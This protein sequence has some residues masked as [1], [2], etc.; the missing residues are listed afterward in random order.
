MNSDTLHWMRLALAALNGL[1]FA[2]GVLWL[3]RTAWF[4][5]RRWRQ[6]LAQ[7]LAESSHEEGSH[8]PEREREIDWLRERLRTWRNDPQTLLRL[9]FAAMMVAISLFALFA[10]TTQ[11]W[12]LLVR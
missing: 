7:L 9:A 4:D 11:P 6:R 8:D 10:L 2:V 12:S 3:L 1:L 5:P